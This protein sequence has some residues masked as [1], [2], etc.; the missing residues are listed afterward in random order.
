MNQKV[1]YLLVPNYKVLVYD[2]PNANQLQNDNINHST[3][4]QDTKKEFVE[5]AKFG[6]KDNQEA[7]DQSKKISIGTPNGI[8]HRKQL[9]TTKIN[10]QVPMNEFHL[11]LKSNNNS[12]S[13]QIDNKAMAE[14]ILSRKGSPKN[15]IAAI[16]N[17][18]NETFGKKP[19]S[20]RVQSPDSTMH[21]RLTEEEMPMNSKYA[22]KIS[23]NLKITQSPSTSPKRNEGKAEGK[24]NENKKDIGSNKTQSPN[25]KNFSKARF[26]SPENFKLNEEKSKNIAKKNEIKYDEIPASSK[27]AKKIEVE[28]NKI[29]IPEES[30]KSKSAKNTQ[31]NNKILTKIINS[32][33]PPRNQVATQAQAQI[34]SSPRGHRSEKS[35]NIKSIPPSPQTNRFD[36]QDSESIRPITS[37]EMRSKSKDEELRKKRFKSQDFYEDVSKMRPN[38]SAK[39]SINV[40]NLLKTEKIESKKKEF[41]YDFDIK[42]KSK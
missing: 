40:I 13:R 36:E 38:T 29:E 33:S 1:V 22:K 3:L 32:S 2:N 5:T 24:A 15:V 6:L 14:I 18:K 28:M 21:K 34:I 39:E 42:I 11:K 4:Y 25:S 10:G 41:L 20:S 16:S 12:P 35:V 27:Y 17:I 8:S 30:K 31:Q 23:S 26:F 37:Y 7:P 9:S 19:N